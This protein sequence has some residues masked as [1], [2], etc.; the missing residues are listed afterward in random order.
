[1]TSPCATTRTSAAGSSSMALRQPAHARAATAAATAAHWSLLQCPP[2][3]AAP[4]MPNEG[5]EAPEAQAGPEGAVLER[6]SGGLR[7]PRNASPTLPTLGEPRA[8]LTGQPGLVRFN[9]CFAAAAAAAAGAWHG[10]QP[11]T[12][13]GASVC[14]YQCLH[15]IAAHTV[16]HR[17]ARSTEWSG[18]LP[19]L[20]AS[21]AH[22]MAAPRRAWAIGMPSTL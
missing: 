18:K 7:P 6:D 11:A 22:G 14:T 21:P 9:F 16:M 3:P 8:N 13:C 15:T 2:M 20:C 5:S 1:M 12:P 10:G 19:V 4:G 17:S